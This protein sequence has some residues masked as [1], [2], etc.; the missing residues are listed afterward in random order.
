MIELLEYLD[1][2]ILDFGKQSYCA[3]E[4]LKS[5][6]LYMVGSERSSLERL[7]CP[8]DLTQ[9]LFPRSHLHHPHRYLFECHLKKH[10][11]LNRHHRGAQKAT[12]PHQLMEW[13]KK[14]KA[15]KLSTFININY[16]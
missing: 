13:Q 5:I 6:E 11:S 10:D 12:H 3:F 16:S 1:I 8:K 7:S 2:E 15:R 14:S 9:M 4:V